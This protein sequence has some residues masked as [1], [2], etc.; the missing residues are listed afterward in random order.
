MTEPAEGTGPGADVRAPR[1]TFPRLRRLDATWC[2]IEQLACGAMF[3]FMA[4]IVFATVLR[5]TFYARHNPLDAIIL[6]AIVLGAM[7][8][9]TSRSW[10]KPRSRRWKAVVALVATVVLIGLV[11]LYVTLLPGGLQWTS[12]AALCLMLWVGFLGAS[13]ATHDKAHL[14]LELGEKLW[15]KRVKHI[16]AAFAH[17]ITAACCVILFLLSIESLTAHHANWVA[18]DGYADT[19]PTMPWLPQW[20]VFMIFPYTFLAMTLRFMAQMVTTATRT[21]ARPHEGET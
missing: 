6:F 19:I 1:P 20:V 9:R 3:L 14:A 16:V 4:L 13:I 12:K 11:E 5:D 10:D 18:A 15:P 2:R 21:E 8:T 7:F 17:A